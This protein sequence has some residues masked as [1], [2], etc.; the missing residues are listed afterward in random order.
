MGFARRHPV[1]TGL[2]TSAAL[3]AAGLYGAGKLGYL[4]HGAKTARGM[5]RTGVRAAKLAKGGRLTEA[6][7]ARTARLATKRAGSA[8]RMAARSQRE[9]AKSGGFLHGGGAVPKIPKPPAPFRPPG[10]AAGLAPTAA[11][12]TASSG[13]NPGLNRFQ[14]RAMNSP[15]FKSKQRRGVFA[16]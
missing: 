8:G 7:E 2:A 4:G 5:V 10:L 11:S 9:A 12:S 3:G 1:L 13:A 6:A 14:R 16:P 15:R